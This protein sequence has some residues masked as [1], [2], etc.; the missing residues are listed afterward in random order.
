M[1]RLRNLLRALLVTRRS[2][3]AVALLFVVAVA[4]GAATGFWLLFR[5]AYLIAIGVPVAWL[6]ARVNAAGLSVRIERFADR[7]QEG[8]A[9]EG[10]I[11]IENRGWFGKL[12]L[13][14]EDRS[15]LPGYAVRRVV[16]IPR[17]G[18]RTW[19]V[20]GPASRRGVYSVGPVQVTAAD[21]FGLF[22]KTVRFGSPRPVL[23]FPRA[24]DLAGFSVPLAHLPGEGRFRRPTQTLTPNAA[25]VR[26]YAPGDAFNRIHWPTTVRTGQLM[27]K[28]FEL[29]PASDIWVALDLHRA[30][31]AGEGEAGTE[32][33][34]VHVAASVVRH[35]LMANRS[36]GFLA[37]GREYHV[38]EPDRGAQQYG[39]ILE[40]LA[41]ARAVGDVPLG[42][43]LANEAR[44]FGRHT[45]VVVITPATDDA[46]VASL[47]QIAQRGARTAAILIEAETFGA[48]RSS[49]LAYSAL[50][51]SDVPTFTLRRDADPRVALAR[52]AAALGGAWR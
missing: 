49:L 29:D 50:A 1:T 27:V 4:G 23:V 18:R 35:F 30:A 45:T 5:L 6:W 46:W 17:G 31:H 10:R 19:L 14:V 51:A 37:Y 33:Y 44:R 34:A 13:E 7:V 38:E 25:G 26:P 28:V 9:V 2:Q 36:V 47:N 42:E 48:D 21:P 22:R 52:E 15:D 11:T 39:R 16:S 32:E 8:Q 40:D 12:W 3:T 43:L 24:V 20:R 41:L